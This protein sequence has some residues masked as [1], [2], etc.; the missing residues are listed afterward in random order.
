M[1]VESWVVRSLSTRPFTGSV[2]QRYRGERGSDE[3][4]PANDSLNI[5]RL[6]EAVEK[7][8]GLS[9]KDFCGSGKSARTVL[10]KEMLVLTA[11]ELGAKMTFLSQIMGLSSGSVSKR[12]DAARLKVCQNQELEKLAQRILKEYKRRES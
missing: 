8:C 1:K 2:K 6:I 4:L 11:H 10:A 9:R 12:H 5:D 7:V 3:C